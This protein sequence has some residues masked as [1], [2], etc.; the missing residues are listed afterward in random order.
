[1][2]IID[3]VKDKY[4]NHL[5][6]MLN[7]FIDDA[8]LNFQEIRLLQRFISDYLLKDCREDDAE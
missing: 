8:H 7:L 4:A 2:K 6:E 1:M 3:R 5:M